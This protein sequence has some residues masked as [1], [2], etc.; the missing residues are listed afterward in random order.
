MTLWLFR[1][2]ICGEKR[3]REHLGERKFVGYGGCWNSVDIQRAER[4]EPLPISYEILPFEPC[5]P[6]PFCKLMSLETNRVVH[7]A[8]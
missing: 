6:G 4:V 2:C 5:H 8:Q 7:G 3:F 1:P